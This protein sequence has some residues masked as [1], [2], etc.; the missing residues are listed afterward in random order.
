MKKAFRSAER[1]PGL[2]AANHLNRAIDEAGRVLAGRETELG[3]DHPDTLMARH[4]LGS[5]YIAAGRFHEAINLLEQNRDAYT[6]VL[7]EDHPDSLGSR[8]N[9]ARAYHSARRPAEAI[10]LLEPTLAACVR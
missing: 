2:E 8:N 6:R 3:T 10:S 4:K 5:A 9:L 7:G 1:K